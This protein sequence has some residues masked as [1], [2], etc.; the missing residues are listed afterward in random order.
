MS[1]APGQ[2]SRMRTM[3]RRAV[4]MMRAGACQIS[5]RSRLG[6]ARAKAPV[7]H[8][9]WNH[10]TSPLPATTPDRFKTVDSG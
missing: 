4:V 10:E 9:I 6:R 1:S 7:R 5:Q 3:S 2:V 8:S